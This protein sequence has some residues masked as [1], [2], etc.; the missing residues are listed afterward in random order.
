MSVKLT[1]YKSDAEN[2]LGYIL[3]ENN[4][5]ELITLDID[6]DAFLIAAS[7]SKLLGIEVEEDKIIVE[8]E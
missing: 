8:V 3:P 2:F 7:Y 1:Y 5:Q 4:W 6:S